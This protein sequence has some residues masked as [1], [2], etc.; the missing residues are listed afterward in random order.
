MRRCI[1]YPTKI[2]QH[3]QD[4]HHDI[5]NTQQIDKMVSLGARSLMS[6]TSMACPLCRGSNLTRKEY[7]SHVGRHQQ[8]L[9][10]F[11]LPSLAAEYVDNEGSDHDR[12]AS[13]TSR[14]TA[15]LPS[16]HT[17]TTGQGQ[18]TTRN[19]R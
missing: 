2:E 7:Q 4:C 15:S 14:D 9:A 18:E 3:V 10:I 8:D 16:V 6:T 12:E 5:N 1:P 19:S 13:V 17:D 11:A